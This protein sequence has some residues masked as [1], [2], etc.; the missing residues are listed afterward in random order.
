MI[1]RR[2]LDV[3]ECSDSLCLEGFWTNLGAILGWFVE[4]LWAYINARTHCVQS[5]C[6]FVLGEVVWDIPVLLPPSWIWCGCGLVRCLSC[7]SH[8]YR[9]FDISFWSDCFRVWRGQ[10]PCFGLL[11]SVWFVDLWSGHLCSIWFAWYG[12][13]WPWPSVLIDLRWS[14]LS[15]R[16]CLCWSGGVPTVLV[17]SSWYT[18]VR[19]DLVCSV[20]RCPSLVCS[21][22][23]ALVWSM[24]LCSRQA[25]SH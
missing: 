20:L 1:F 13:V 6:F 14:H 2:F 7:C 5:A 24:M 11:W 22:W 21:L 18:L 16:F 19:S 4:G 8:V 15:G 9:C 23:S 3:Y 12:F 17:W 10:E 25:C